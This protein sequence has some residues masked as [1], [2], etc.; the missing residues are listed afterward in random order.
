MFRPRPRGRLLKPAQ[1][2]VACSISAVCFF[3]VSLWA[4]EAPAV[5]LRA[6]WQPSPD[7]RVVGYKLHYG[8]SS[9]NYTTVVNTAS[10]TTCT[11]TDLQQTRTYYFAASAYDAQGNASPFSDEIAFT[12][13]STPV[14]TAPTA[15]SGVLLV[16]EDIAAS[17]TLRATDAEGDALTFRITSSPGLG[18]VKLDNAATGAFTYT[19]NRDANGSDSFGFVAND[20]KLDSSQATVSVTITPVNDPPVAVADKASTTQGTTVSISVLANDSDPDGDILSLAS[21]SQGAKGTTALSGTVVRYTPSADFVGTDT[22]T[23]TVMD[24]KGAT[25]TGTVTVTVSATNT[26][27]DTDPKNPTLLPQDG[28]TLKYVDSQE[29]IGENGAAENAFDNDPTTFWHTQWAG[30]SPKHPHEIQIDLGGVFEIQG[31]QYLPRQDGTSNGRI[32]QYELYVSSDGFN[33]GSPVVTGVFSNDSNVKQ[34]SFA[35]ATG[36]CIRLRALSEANDNPWTSVAEIRLL[37]NGQP[38]TS[39]LSQ[40]QWTLKY[41]DSQELYGENGSAQNAFDNDPTTFWHTEWS[42]SN[43]AAPHEI[44]VDLGGMYEI[45]GFR[46]LPRQDG[47]VNGQIAKYEFYVSSDGVNWGTAVIAGTFSRDTSEKQV[48]FAPKL[49]KFIRLRSLTEVN[50]NPWTSVAE[51]RVVGSQQTSGLL[52]RDSWTLK[53]VDSQELIGENGA[54]KNAFDNNP[55][56][57]WHTQWSSGS[58]AHPHEIQISLGGTYEVQGFRYLPRQDGSSNGRIKQYELYVSTDGVNWGSP[59]ASG[60]F[61]NDAKEKE[62]NSTPKSGKF[63]RLRS[64]SEVNG[65]P[66][67]SMAEFQLLGR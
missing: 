23:Y 32:K 1:K 28:W 38:M 67:A 7:S 14:N 60:N 11:L 50:G 36:T 9:G 55:S 34:V 65:N 27:S 25:A 58:P 8:Q 61:S 48:S 22:F 15:S 52:P 53:Y 2:V 57:F 30:S 33:W 35:T 5:T 45:Q 3:L 42:R 21:A 40:S 44:Q 29:L 37:G 39:L 64:L 43:P 19:P 16:T 24:G 54:A 31:F 41:A 66:W 4:S 62:V 47:S 10:Q 63:V 18:T 49:G 46:Y 59:V 56:T 26:D 17:G 6:S 20:G 13:P 51:L 12:V